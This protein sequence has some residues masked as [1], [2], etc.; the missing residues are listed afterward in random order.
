MSETTD[1]FEPVVVPPHTHVRFATQHKDEEVLLVVRRVLITQFPWVIN[2][3]IFS[4]LALFLNIFLQDILT[5]NQLIVLDLF[6]FFFIFSYAWVNYLLWYFTI[7]LVTNERIIDLDFYHL[8][9]KEFSATTI[10]K[11]SD[12]TTKVGGFLGSIFNYGN[13]YVKTQGFQQ[14]I[15][16]EDVR[17]P[18]D[19]VKLIN[20]LMKRNHREGVVE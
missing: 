9:Y 6:S 7:G 2:T 13:V 20:S 18:Q 10:R 15:E 5:T 14:D 8:V 19:V 12:I 16:F 4:L 17:H 1:T 11:V 3:I